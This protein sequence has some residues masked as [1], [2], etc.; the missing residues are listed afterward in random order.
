MCGET[1]GPD[2]ET[3]DC[4]SS[5]LDQVDDLRSKLRAAEEE[6]DRREH[7]QWARAE[8]A[9]SRLRLYEN[10]ERAVS[11]YLDFR[12]PARMHAM[13]EAIQRL[14]ESRGSTDRGSS[15][16]GGETKE[17]SDE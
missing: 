7:I 4:A 3:Y 13:T 12:K 9:E 6:R 17:P 2:H 5:L 1:D 16:T 10:L 15:D 11:D 8:K 14:Q